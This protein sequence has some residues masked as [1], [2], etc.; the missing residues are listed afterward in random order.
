MSGSEVYETVGAA[1]FVRP[2]RPGNVHVR[3]TPTAARTV[4]GRPLNAGWNVVPSPQPSV[5]GWCL[6]TAA[7]EEREYGWKRVQEVAGG[8]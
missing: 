3:P 6:T 7:A 4:C 2:G 1:S 8:R 5:C